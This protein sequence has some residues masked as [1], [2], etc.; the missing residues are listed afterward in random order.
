MDL[1]HR[2]GLGGAVG[3]NLLDTTL[4]ATANSE[5]RRP[6]LPA[7]PPSLRFSC[8]DTVLRWPGGHW[9]A[10]R[11]DE[12][13]RTTAVRAARGPTD[14]ARG[15]HPCARAQEH[16]GGKEVRVPNNAVT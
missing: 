14:T 13:A 7:L 11:E 3:G 8:A 15:L 5:S 4:K 9:A 6:V 2:Q 12:L 1:A 16:D 10:A